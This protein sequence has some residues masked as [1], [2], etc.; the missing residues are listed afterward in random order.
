M[1]VDDLTSMVREVNQMQVAPE[2]RL[3]DNVYKYDAKT[4]TLSLADECAREQKVSMVSENT[5]TY[6]AVSP[7]REENVN[8]EAARPRHRR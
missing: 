2:E 1:D 3:S 4:K 7:V 6:G 8:A 5:G